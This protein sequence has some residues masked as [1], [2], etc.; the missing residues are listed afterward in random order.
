MQYLY[1]LHVFYQPKALQISVY[2]WGVYLGPLHN[3][4]ETHTWESVSESQY[5][6]NGHL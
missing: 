2:I 5:W 3:M 6:I 4:L 1:D